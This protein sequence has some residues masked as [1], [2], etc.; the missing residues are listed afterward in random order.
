MILKTIMKLQKKK[1]IKLKINKE[2]NNQ[3]NINSINDNIVENNN[4]IINTIQTEKK[5]EDIFDF[6]EKKDEINDIFGDSNSNENLKE[7]IITGK[8]TENINSIFDTDNTNISNQNSQPSKNISQ[9][10]FSNNSITYISVW[11][12]T[13]EKTTI[14][15]IKN[16]I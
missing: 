7:N 3:I 4:N 8:D 5:A 1:K 9:T 11:S 6:P 13:N 15:Y 16:K 12:S 14:K 10:P 2:T